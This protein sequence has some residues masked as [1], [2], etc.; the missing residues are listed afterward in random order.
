VGTVAVVVTVAA[1]VR[2]PA[3][4]PGAGRCVPAGRSVSEGPAAAVPRPATWAPGAGAGSP[5]AV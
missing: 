3:A 5:H 1:V 4:L 2:T